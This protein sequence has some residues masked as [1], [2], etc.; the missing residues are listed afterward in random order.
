MATAHLLC[1]TSRST[2]SPLRKGTGS[3]RWGLGKC[4]PTQICIDTTWGGAGKVRERKSPERRCRHQGQV[5]V[6]RGPLGHRLS[7]LLNGESGVPGTGE[8]WTRDT[9]IEKE[10]HRR[11]SDKGG[12]ERWEENSVG[13]VRYG[14]RKYLLSPR[15]RKMKWGREREAGETSNWTE[16]R[17]TQNWKDRG[18]E[19]ESNRQSEEQGKKW[20][21]TE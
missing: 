1:G 13:R 3:G 11:G 16:K 8:R 17:D 10:R 7:S 14:Y 21:D 12:G 19:R 5:G 20:P 6:G 9:W 4:P 18:T 2:F 15:G